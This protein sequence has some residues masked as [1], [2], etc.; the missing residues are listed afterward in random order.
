MN[1]AVANDTISRKSNVPPANVANDDRPIVV[2]RVSRKP[3]S[4][5][6]DPI[7][8]FDTCFY[9]TVL[10]DL[11]SHLAKEFSR[12]LEEFQVFVDRAFPKMK[13]PRFLPDD[14]GPS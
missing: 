7:V 11:D 12:V 4:I 1:M 9:M 6:A 8:V 14:F 10:R 2:S 5:V 3:V 13:I